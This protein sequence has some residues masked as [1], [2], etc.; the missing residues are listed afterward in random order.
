MPRATGTFDVKL[1][2]QPLADVGAD[3]L[4]GRRSIDKRFSGDLAGTSKGEMLSAGSSVAGSAGYVAIER[5]NATLDGRQGTFVLQHFATMPRGTPELRIIVVPD[6]GGGD[7][8][9][10]TGTMNIRIEAK[11]HYYDFAYTLERSS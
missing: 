8:A 2:A 3:A 4:L 5:V 9:G 7:L 1:D 6:S 11:V 10:I